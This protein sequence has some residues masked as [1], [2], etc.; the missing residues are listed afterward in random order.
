MST[1]SVDR[2]RT[3][4]PFLRVLLL[5]SALCASP[6]HASVKGEWSANVSRDLSF[7]RILVVGISP[8]RNQRCR[9][10]RAM[11]SLIRSA[12]AEAFV[13]CDV[14]PAQTPLTRESIEAAVAAE[15]A[16]AVFTTS[17][18]STAWETE[19]GG[20]SD[21]SGIANYK[22]TDA[23]YGVY[24]TVVAVDFK[25]SAAIDTV[26]G[27]AHV[28]SKLYQ[29]RDATVVYTLDTKVRKIASLDEG[30][31]AISGQIGKKLLRE[32]LIR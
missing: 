21:T 32:G 18:V 22:A 16:D 26:E 10:E 27:K 3:T 1:D 8:D 24:G 4:R 5:L 30:L 11:A 9:F 6:S 23:Y 13:S 17:L 19:Q 15:D 7:S 20:T 25:T 31:A 14:I 2:Q 12:D 28:T 29:T